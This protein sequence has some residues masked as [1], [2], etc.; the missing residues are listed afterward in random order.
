MHKITKFLDKPMN[1]GTIES[2]DVDLLFSKNFRYQGIGL[3]NCVLI[4]DN[5]KLTTF[6][7]RLENDIKSSLGKVRILQAPDRDK[8]DKNY[9]SE[10]FT[11]NLDNPFAVKYVF[12]VLGK[13][14][15]LDKNG[16]RTQFPPLQTK[17]DRDIC[18]NKFNEI[19]TKVKIG[20][21][22]MTYDRSSQVSNYIR[23]IDGSQ[24]SHCGSMFDE[25]QI[26]EMT[27]EGMERSPL[28][29]LD[30]HQYDI[31]VYRP[32][33]FLSSTDEQISEFLLRSEKLYSSG[34]KYNWNGILK[35]FLMRKYPK[36]FRALR[37]ST[38]PTMSDLI[39]SNE[40]VLIDWI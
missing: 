9:L 27:T 24:W 19:L 8:I 26:Q 30:P 3:S 40:F 22:I 2:R 32:Y 37:K 4:L 34:A 1:Q 29:F 11:E 5:K 20:D 38:G 28:A 13:G 25:F 36:L 16:I 23:K 12:Q 6:R 7:I 18:K 17:P 21:L 14:F 10:Y 35:V 31:A 15:N 39:N 33:D